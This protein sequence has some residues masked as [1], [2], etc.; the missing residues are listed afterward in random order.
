MLT[1]LLQAAKSTESAMRAIGLQTLKVQG[2]LRNTLNT[3]IRCYAKKD[4]VL[5]EVRVRCSGAVELARA[6][7]LANSP[8][9][10]DGVPSAAVLGDCTVAKLLLMLTAPHAYCS[11]WGLGRGRH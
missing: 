3:V 1:H 10:G 8:S 11:C 5:V 2:S 9:W 6:V 7:S 4:T